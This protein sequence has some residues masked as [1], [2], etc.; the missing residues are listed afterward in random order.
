MDTPLTVARPQ[1]PPIGDC[2]DAFI[3][4]P[5]GSNPGHA[6]TGPMIA[7][8]APQL[9]LGLNTW[10]AGFAAAP[11]R[12][13]AFAPLA[14]FGFAPRAIVPSIRVR[15]VPGRRASS[16]ALRRIRIA[17]PMG[18]TIADIVFLRLGDHAVLPRRAFWGI[19]RPRQISI[20]CP[21]Q[22]GH[23]VGMRAFVV[24]RDAVQDEGDIEP[25]AVFVAEA[26]LPRFGFGLGER[27]ALL[28]DRWRIDERRVFESITL[29][30]FDP[31]DLLA[32]RARSSSV[33]LHLP[34]DIHYRLFWL[35]FKAGKLT[36]EPEMHTAATAETKVPALRAVPELP[37]E[38]ELRRELAAAIEANK[39]AA[40]RA[41]IAGDAERRARVELQEAQAA[42]EKLE[43]TQA[44][45]SQDAVERH[46]RLIAGAIRAGGPLPPNTPAM[47]AGMA[48]LSPMW[49]QRDA[50]QAALDELIA[51]ANTAKSEVAR[52][53]DMVAKAADAVVEREARGVAA[54][55]IACCELYWR[56]AERFDA[57]ALLDEHRPDG[58][59]LDGFRREVRHKT[60]RRARA[61]ADRHEFV[62]MQKWQEHLAGRM[63]AQERLWQAYRLALMT[64]AQ[65]RWTGDE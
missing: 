9:A 17:L 32:F 54:E 38:V 11:P 19:A 53:S 10:K 35:S 28:G 29:I 23:M 57:F 64:N 49:A 25:C 16:P 6:V 63:A 27:F 30:H 46:A 50:L 61:T 1:A 52:A 55:L 13:D 62:E 60:D 15:E 51:E 48:S 33:K 26:L 45:A 56:L 40:G 36:K 4:E 59:K 42:L 44:R 22:R 20:M 39:V 65:A 8:T 47:P 41:Q 37:N 2:A 18:H 58:P 12:H 24:L 43:S 14:R 3:R 34:L 31:Q 7:I 5:F 21:V